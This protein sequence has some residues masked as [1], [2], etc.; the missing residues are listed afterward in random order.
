MLNHNINYIKDYIIKLNANFVVW[1]SV[2]IA[3]SLTIALTCITIDFSHFI[4]DTSFIVLKSTKII[5]INL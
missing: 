2:S 4:V 1:F 3:Y 5:Q